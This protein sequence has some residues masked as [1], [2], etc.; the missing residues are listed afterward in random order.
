VSTADDSDGSI[1]R[2]IQGVKAADRAAF[3]ELFK[4]Y[5][6]RLVAVARGRLKGA[7]A[8]RTADEEDVALSAI[9]SFWNGAE[10][11]KF[12]Q[13]RDREN[14]WPLLVLITVRKAID[15]VHK[16]NR[17]RPLDGGVHGD[18][19]FATTESVGRG[20]DDL[21]VQRPSE[22]SMVEWNETLQRL[23]SLLEDERSQQIALLK[24][25]QCT[26][27]E[28]AT[29]LAVSRATVSRKLRLIRRI[30]ERELNAQA[31]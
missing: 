15:A 25:Q 22:Q 7:R 21:L 29:Q 28:I 20:L 14:L 6:E 31:E 16:E 24:L 13:L 2:L 27:D 3:D 5:F 10:Q 1:T 30:W 9:H 18:S 11:G 8:Q 4:A 26:D 17:R 12:D 19:L 23:L